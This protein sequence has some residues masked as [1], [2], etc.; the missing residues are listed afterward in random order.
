MASETDESIA[1]ASCDT[2]EIEANITRIYRS[3]PAELTMDITFEVRAPLPYKFNATASPTQITDDTGETWKPKNTNILIQS[4]MF[5]P[6]TK[7]KIK[8]RLFNESGGKDATVLNALLGF[9]A[10]S[11][12]GGKGRICRLEFQKVPISKK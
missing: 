9:R 1:S 5:P 11:A 2:P 7:R 4:G 6:N 3:G 8:Y 12:E 10:F